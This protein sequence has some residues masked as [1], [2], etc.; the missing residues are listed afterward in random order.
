VECDCGWYGS[1]S[2]I[3]LECTF[4]GTREE[5]PEYEGFC[6]A[7]GNPAD[8]S[9]KDV[10]MCKSCEDVYVKDEGD[11]CPECHECMMEDKHDGQREE[12]RLL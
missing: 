7:C 2:D 3:V 11:V 4:H 6:P 10:P 9:I 5:P 12:G 8:D 1:D